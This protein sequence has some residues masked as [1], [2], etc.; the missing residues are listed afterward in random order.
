M[1]PLRAHATLLLLGCCLVTGGA[2]AQS[3]Q[4][5]PPGDAADGLPGFSRVAWPGAER[6]ALSLSASGG[7]SLLEGQ[8]GEDGDHHRG[9]GTLAAGLSLRDL[10]AVSLRFDGRLDLHPDDGMG[11]HAGAVGD[12][13]FGL[14]SAA[15]P[16]GERVVL[17]AGLSLWAPGAEA[18]SVELA[19]S[20]LD[21]QL[22]LGFH[23]STALRIGLSAG[24]RL[25]RSHKSID[26]PER[27]RAGDRLVL[28]VSDFDAALLGLGASYQQGA[29]EWLAECSGDLLL[30][31][32][33]PPVRGSPLRAGLGAR[34]DVA[35][36]WQL[37]LWL[38][39]GLGSAVDQGPTDPLVPIQPRFGMRA[40]LRY[41]FELDPP[42]PTSE[43]EPE[44]EPTPVAETAPDPAPAAPPVAAGPSSLHGRVV[45]EQGGAV[46]GA[47][48]V[49]LTDDAMAETDSDAEGR[50]RIEPAAPGTGTLTMT[51]K[52]LAEVGRSL[53]LS[54]GQSQEVQLETR[55]DVPRAQLRGTVRSRGGK[56]L[57]AT[58]TI[59]PAKTKFATDAEGYFEADVEPGDYK[60]RIRA[61]G[62]RSQNRDVV[63]QDNGVTVLNVE[64][65]KK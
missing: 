39:A 16:L 35:S 33:A 63:V 53:E 22:L 41:R 37:S 56:R 60:V 19:A 36:A 58:I 34:H 23:A 4:S 55:I 14:R 15:L 32:G 42:P 47:H 21:A 11:S 54:Q 50:F 2:R 52:G 40:G 27:L 62:F 29:T 25:D 13:R 38:E 5:A 26:A 30:G 20:T 6:T 28:G 18:P 44:P 17:G 65:K 10:L 51:A 49:W 45:D 3:G 57:T 61:Y 64:L 8:P 24:Y 12:P 9:F 48:L 46:A 59:Y 43:P 7:Y 1:G 31:D